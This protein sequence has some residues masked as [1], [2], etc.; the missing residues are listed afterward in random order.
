[1]GVWILD[2]GEPHLRKAIACVTC[3]HPV[4]PGCVWCGMPVVM[5]TPPMLCV[6]SCEVTLSAFNPPEVEKTFGLA[7]ATD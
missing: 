5:L 2:N 3:L 1:M 4:G 7:S 6:P